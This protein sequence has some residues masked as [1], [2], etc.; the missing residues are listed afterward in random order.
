MAQN[1]PIVRT[2]A[3]HDHCVIM[4]RKSFLL[5]WN[6][7]HGKKVAHE[8]QRILHLYSGNGEIIGP[9]SWSNYVVALEPDRILAVKAATSYPYGDFRCADPH[10]LVPQEGESMDI[11]LLFDLDN[12]P[13]YSSLLSCWM[14]VSKFCCI[15][16]PEP[17]ND[18]VLAV[19]K[20]S[21]H[22]LVAAEELELND[23]KMRFLVLKKK[24]VTPS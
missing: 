11:L 16:Y 19:I 1:P 24:S 18:E 13:S 15:S 17:M 5:A 8:F 6:T 3:L 14:P 9:H 10:G 4:A 7:N 2:K 20:S 23:T 12:V 21:P 22:E